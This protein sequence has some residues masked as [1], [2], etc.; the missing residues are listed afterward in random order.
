[1]PGT[2][3]T[4]KNFK[5]EW[6]DAVRQGLLA[7]LD[8][9]RIT[10]QEWESLTSI[11]FA[12]D[13]ALHVYLRDLYDYLFGGSEQRPVLPGDG[14]ERPCLVAGGRL[15]EIPREC[16]VRRG[17]VTRLPFGSFE[18]V[19]AVPARGGLPVRA[20]SPPFPVKGEVALFHGKLYRTRPAVGLRPCVE[21]LPEPGC[22]APEGLAPG[23]AANG[24]VG[25]P[26]PPERLEAWYALRWTF[27]WHDEPFECAVATAGTLTGD[28]LVYQG[29]TYPAAAE[30]DAS[31]LIA[32]TTGPDRPG[33]F[34][35][36]PRD[37]GSGQFLA[38]PEQLD[39]WY[40]THWTFRWKGG[41]FDAVGTV[42]GRIRGVY[43]GGSWGF[44]DNHMLTEE[45]AP[46]GFR[47]TVTAGLRGVTDF[48]E[49]RTDLLANQ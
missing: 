37:S 22:P 30:A 2:R 1:M 26:A 6:T 25:Y 40:R 28:Y 4:L 11:E 7:V 39:A 43:T 31:G 18:G 41:P 33:G 19:S 13:D 32:L 5:R 42:D 14:L 47:Y 10:G 20:E 45:R 24:S 44:A 48:E 49:R 46:D 34:V 38:A 15:S 27:R 29:R 9:K 17:Q 23:E 3:E 8:E 21:L 35:D 16:T 36:D 12:T